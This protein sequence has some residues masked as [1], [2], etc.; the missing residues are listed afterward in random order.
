[1][2]TIEPTNPSSAAKENNTLVIRLESRVYKAEDADQNLCKTCGDVDCIIENGAYHIGRT[3]LEQP[4]YKTCQYC[5]AG[6]VVRPSG[7]WQYACH[8]D[9][10]KKAFK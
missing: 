10:I 9:E 2:D 3:L 4:D 6:R 1:M 5:G 7:E 8:C